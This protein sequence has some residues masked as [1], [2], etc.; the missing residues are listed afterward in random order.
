MKS[1]SRYLVRGLVLVGLAIFLSLSVSAQRRPYRMTD[2]QVAQLVPAG[3]YFHGQAAATQMR[4]AGAVRFGDDRYVIAGMVDTSGYSADVRASYE[5]FLIADLPIKIN[6]SRLGVGAYGFG[7]TDDGKLHVMNIA[8]DQILSV[9]TAK[10][11]GLRR[12]RPLMMMVDNGG[13]RLYSG[14]QYVSITAE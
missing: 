12:P 6:G 7:F 5:G 2:Q 11:P 10:D 8:G 3:F 14:R 1:R 4:N 13:A 9:S